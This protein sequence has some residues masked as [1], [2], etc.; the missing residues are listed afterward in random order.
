MTPEL[1]RPERSRPEMSR[2]VR[3]HEIGV[4][5]R[6]VVVAAD[7]TERAA[8]A[9]RFDLVAL[10]ALTATLTVH[11]DAAGIRVA[12][13]LHAAGAQ[14]C[15]VS[16]EPVAFAIDETIDLIFSDAAVPS[17]DEVELSDADLDIL[18]LDG[19]ALDLGEAVAQSLGLAL[20]P[21]PRGADADRAA[22]GLVISEAEAAA[23][24]AADTARASPF[25]ALR[26]R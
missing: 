26:R 11:R 8:L 2:I 13:P 12:G 9:A 3:A 1:P 5:R 16:A 24:A 10:D 17:G 14:A 22:A 4:A 6:T 7:A 25:A 18:P 21:Y 23:M 19:D 15:V 20:D